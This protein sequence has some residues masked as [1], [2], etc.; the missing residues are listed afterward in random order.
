MGNSSPALV[1]SAG[2][3]STFNRTPDSNVPTEVKNHLVILQLKQKTNFKKKQQ[4]FKT[5]IHQTTNAV[6]NNNNS[7]NKRTETT[8][9]TSVKQSR[10]IVMFI[11]WFLCDYQIHIHLVTGA[12]FCWALHDHGVVVLLLVNWLGPAPWQQQP[13]DRTVDRPPAIITGVSLVRSTGG[14]GDGAVRGGG[15]GVWHV[16]ELSAARRRTNCC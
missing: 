2:Y 3:S 11:W 7:N 4:Q 6:N 16:R 10:S 14:G 13:S 15:E 9:I 5:Y 12:I 1:G 8:I